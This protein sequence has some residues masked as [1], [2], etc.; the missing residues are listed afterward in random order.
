MC[1]FYLEVIILPA[2][3]RVYQNVKQDL[4]TSM[5]NVRN[6]LD[7]VQKVRHKHNYIAQFDILCNNI[8]SCLSILQ[9]SSDLWLEQLY[10]IVWNLTVINNVKTTTRLLVTEYAVIQHLNIRISHCL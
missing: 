3:T 1:C 6:V 4:S 7:H 2:P 9:Y 5:E 8:F 10:P